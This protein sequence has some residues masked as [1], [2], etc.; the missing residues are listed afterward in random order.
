[1]KTFGLRQIVQRDLLGSL[2]EQK[3]QTHGCVKRE[4]SSIQQ[5]VLTDGAG[6]MKPL[7]S[8]SKVKSLEH[9]NDKRSKRDCA[10][11]MAEC[12]LHISVLGGLVT[13]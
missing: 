10:A 11:V 1:M 4:T 2:E 13:D 7:P 3:P 6:K 5:F 8:I 9:M 12:L